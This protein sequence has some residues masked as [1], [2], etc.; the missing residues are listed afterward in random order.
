MRAK[1][2]FIEET[3]RGEKIIREAVLTDKSAKQLTKGR[4]A[5]LLAGAYPDLKLTDRVVLIDTELG[6]SAVKVI[7]PRKGVWLKVYV[8]ELSN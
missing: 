6:W 7:Q 2:K 1:V 3:H 8:A 5:K 4:A